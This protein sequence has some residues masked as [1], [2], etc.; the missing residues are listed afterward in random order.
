MKRNWDWHGGMEGWNGEGNKNGLL[1]DP[2]YFFEKTHICDD[3]Y[4]GLF[5]V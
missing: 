1:F 2:L 3:T 5:I 4:P